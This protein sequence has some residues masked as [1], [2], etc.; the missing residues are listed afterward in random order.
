MDVTTKPADWETKRLETLAGYDVLDTPPE[1]TFDRIARVAAEIADCPIALVSLVDKNRQW[2][3]A[4]VGLSVD[5]TPRNVSFCARAVESGEGLVVENALEDPR[6]A[7]NP[8]VLTAPHIRFYAGVLVRGKNSM[9]LGT[10]CVI[11]RSARKLTPDQ[12]SALTALARE[13]ESQLELRK[14]LADVT[15]ASVARQELTAL[16]VHDLRNPLTAILLLG[17]YLMSRPELDLEVASAVD[18]MLGSG[19]TLMRMTRDLLDVSRSDAGTLEPILMEVASRSLIESLAASARRQAQ[20]TSHEIIT[21]SSVAN[22]EVV[23]DV[24]LVRRTV[25]NF[26][27]NALKYAPENTAVTLE[28]TVDEH[29]ELV[30]RVRDEGPSI[31]P[32]HRDEIFDAG[33]RLGSAK[34]RGSLGL[35][36]R[37]CRLAAAALGGRAWLES[38]DAAGNVFALALPRRRAAPAATRA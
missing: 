18:E 11:D 28:A 1:E 17:Q 5:E 4:N 12:M 7:E 38:G 33:F 19:E 34:E 25:E 6:F 35:G 21:R 37:F 3:K 31:P 14:A 22:H 23:T 10:L 32:E 9:P 8:L 36:L 27:E 15:R 16:V 20:F 29:G 13:V 30:I 2:F 26:V 24:D